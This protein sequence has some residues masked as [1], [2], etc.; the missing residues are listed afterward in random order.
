MDPPWQAVADLIRDRLSVT[1]AVIAFRLLKDGD[2]T[3]GVRSFST[4]AAELWDK[5][6]LRYR[7]EVLFDFEAMSAGQLYSLEDRAPGG[8]LEN[9]RVY[10]ELL[11][12]AGIANAYCLP[13]GD[14]D[15]ARAYIVFL[16][17]QLLGALTPDERNWCL[18]VAPHIGRAVELY[19]RIRRAELASDAAGSALGQLATGVLALDERGRIV[20]A[21]RV[22][23][24][25]MAMSPDL[26]QRDNQLIFLREEDRRTADEC[27]RGHGGVRV[28]RIRGGG[29][30]LIGVL[31]KP[32]PGGRELGPNSRP[33]LSIYLHDL[34]GPATGVPSRL[35]AQLFGLS[36]GEAALS[37]RLAE[38]LTVREAAIRIGVTENTARSYSKQVFQKL[39][40]GRQA[41]LVRIILNS[42]AMLG[43]DDTPEGV[44]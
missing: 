30:K 8:Q 14:L 33:A 28:L 34:S 26:A 3:I 15:G 43:G 12:P 21:N 23:E 35:I 16:R 9:V 22:A 27:R 2:A 37:A 25:L 17:P 44:Q 32:I 18:A 6:H 11:V 38:G 1:M 40:V 39:G 7:A 41:D 20:F 4:G 29:D 24:D 42:V 19:A 13:V 10:R 36:P 5:F 31:F